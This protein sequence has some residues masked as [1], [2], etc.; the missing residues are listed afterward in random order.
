[1]TATTMSAPPA[2]LRVTQGRVI[3][4]EWI[5]LRSLR[6][7]L[8]TL[9]AA[10]VLTVGLG[11][12][13]SALRA[14]DITQNGLKPLGFNLTDISLRGINLAMLPIGVLGVLVITGEYST[15]MIRATL[16]AVPKRLPVLWAKVL[17]FAPR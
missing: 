6:S 8:F 16:S 4:S 10:F 11:M 17:V 1:M 13:L 3:N 7:T 14:R 12:L 9:L 15:G 2:R 5:K